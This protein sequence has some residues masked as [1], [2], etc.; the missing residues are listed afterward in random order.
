MR[1][2]CVVTGGAGFIGCALS[3]ALVSRFSSVV[4]VDNLHPQVHKKQGR[5]SNLHPDVQ[6]I[7]DNVASPTFWDQLLSTLHPDTIIHLAAET[8]TGQSLTESSRHVTTNLLGTST[9]L[10]ALVR[11]QMLPNQIVLT[12]SRAV[13]G[14]GLWVD[15]RGRRISPGTRGKV[16]LE[17]GVW[18]FPGLKFVPFS[19]EETPPLPTNV[20]AA[21]KLAQ[22]H[23]LSAWTAAYGVSLDIAR[24]QNV[25]G[26][27]QALQNPYTGIISLFAQL[28]SQGK[29]IALY[30]D[31]EMQRDF[32]FIDDVVS[33]IIA[34]LDQPAQGLRRYDVGLGVRHTIRDAAEIL[35]RHYKSP[36]PYISGAYRLGDVRHAGCQ[37]EPTTALLNWRPKVSL[38]VGLNILCNWIDQS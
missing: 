38:D 20:Y 31:G 21:T 15:E 9:M 10:D 30:E 37:I 19:V 23:I 13:Y 12:S 36:P 7:V 16:Q 32:V 1:Q 14:E 24:L 4:A 35:A 11:H 3:S 2:A 26:P 5:P 8:G 17:A 25:Y 22:E 33:A 29:P 28:S 27:G 34:S 18:D 6:L